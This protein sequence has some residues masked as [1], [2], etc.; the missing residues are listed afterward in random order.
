MLDN[1]EKIIEQ[2]VANKATIR[3]NL[4]PKWSKK[5]KKSRRIQTKSIVSLMKINQNSSVPCLEQWMPS[6]WECKH[7]VVIK[8]NVNIL[9]LINLFRR[10]E[11]L[12]DFPTD[13]RTIVH[14]KLQKRNIKILWLVLVLHF[15]QVM[16]TNTNKVLP[17]PATQVDI[18]TLSTSINTQKMILQKL[19]KW[20]H[21]TSLKIPISNLFIRN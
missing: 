20:T 17:L 12:L 9:I 21:C 6:T 15:K 5:E 3:K 4:T 11:G 1:L 2:E 19:W 16:I 18:K 10:K 8:L 14:L 7:L 13:I